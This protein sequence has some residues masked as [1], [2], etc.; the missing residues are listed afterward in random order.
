MY[1]RSDN[2]LNNAEARES[3]RL[4]KKDAREQALNAFI[5]EGKKTLLVHDEFAGLTISQFTTYYFAD[6]MDGRCAD[7]LVSLTGSLKSNSQTHTFLNLETHLAFID[8]AFEEFF[9]LNMSCITAA[10]DAELSAA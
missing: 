9:E 4:S 6:F 5:E 8:K 7:H 3:R 2:Y 1:T 10:F